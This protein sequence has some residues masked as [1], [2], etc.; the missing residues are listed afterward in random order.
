MS[1]I[2]QGNQ[3][4]NQES[5]SSC[6]KL[7]KEYRERVMSNYRPM[8]RELYQMNPNRFFVPSF[9]NA[10]TE[11]TEEGFRNI[12]SE[13]SPGILTFDMLQPDFC[14]LLLDEVGNIENWLHETRF[15]IMPP[16]TMN[17]Y[18]AVLDDFGLETMLAKLMEDFILPMSTIFFP[19]V[20]GATL[21]SHHGYIVEYGKDRDD[22]LDLH[23][24]DSEVTLNVCLGEQFSGGELFFCGV[25]CDKHINV[26]SEPG[27]IVTYS[28][29]P[30]RAV[31]HRGRHRHGALSTTSGHRV[32]LL[33]WCQSS[34]FRQLRKYEKEAPSWCGACRKEKEERQLRSS[35]ALNL[36][37]QKLLGVRPTSSETDSTSP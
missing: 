15:R 24:D 35:A 29:V 11:N 31:L 19:E 37:L 32:N 5:S 20:G 3:N 13:P 2:S 28:H 26:E 14:K 12:I 25:R 7:V 23:V 34:I 10:I 4:G 36:E 1:T 17:A 16:N 18:G 8:R 6:E 22:H 33:L 30:G 9:L 27:E 21:D